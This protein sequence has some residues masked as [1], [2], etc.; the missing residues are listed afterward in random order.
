MRRIL[1]VL[2]VFGALAAAFLSGCGGG[3]DE[4]IATTASLTKAEFVKQADAICEK[5]NRQGEREFKAVVEKEGLGESPNRKE[6]AES[7][8]RVAVPILEGQI[9]D[10]RALPVPAGEEQKVELILERQE[11]SLE[12]VEEEPLFRV[13][14]NPY[15]ELNKPAADYGLVE[16]SL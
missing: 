4:T 14:G 5:Y 12:K 8:E 1:L 16:C 3:D 7:I 15:E 11:Q 13:S 10:L 2:A 6:V 9:E